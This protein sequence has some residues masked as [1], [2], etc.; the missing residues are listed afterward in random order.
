[1]GGVVGECRVEDREDHRGEGPQGDVWLSKN[2]QGCEE[3]VEWEGSQS[4]DMARC[5]PRLCENN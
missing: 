3:V 4:G 2:Y 5:T 1:M